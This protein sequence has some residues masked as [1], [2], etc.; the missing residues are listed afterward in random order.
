M[1]TPS[2]K[3]YYTCFLFTVYHIDVFVKVLLNVCTHGKCVATCLYS[4]RGAVIQRF[5]QPLNEPARASNM[6]K[7]VSQTRGWCKKRTKTT[8]NTHTGNPR[9]V[10]CIHVKWF[11]SELVHVK[12]SVG[13][14]QSWFLSELVHVKSV[15]SFR[16]YCIG[17]KL[18]KNSVFRM[19][20][21]HCASSL[22]RDH[23]PWYTW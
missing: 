22:V 11:L 2:P 18:K 8:K 21:T 4:E 20:C 14:C 9:R 1:G 7:C 15:I 13:S 6:V 16:K 23:L 3:I 5:E 10:K 12:G 19:C 17:F